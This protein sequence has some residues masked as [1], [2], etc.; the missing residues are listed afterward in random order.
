VATDEPLEEETDVKKTWMAMCA[1]A[2]V[3][4]SGG[5]VAGRALAEDPPAGMD[6]EK[7]IDGNALVKALTANKW[8]TE[9]TGLMA[10]KGA[11]SFRLGAGK[12]LLVEDYDV[13][14]DMGEYSGF[15]VFK[16]SADGK[17]A[18]LWWFDNGAAKPTEFTGPATD[19]GY[20]LTGT[21]SRM[22]GQASKTVLKLTK[23]GD[24]FEFTY[25]EEGTVAF[26][27]TLTKAK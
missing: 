17:T 7:P 2:L 15:G 27:D 12:T 21:V 10:S 16:W 1:V 26:T 6:N 18:T 13:K 8:A 14:G 24:G 25:T 3:A 11:A 19:T 20:E 4:A 5:I 22:P 23:K 9:A